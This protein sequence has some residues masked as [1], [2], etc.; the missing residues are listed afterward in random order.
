MVVVAVDHSV[1]IPVGQDVRLP[2]EDD[3]TS[4]RSLGDGR[5]VRHDRSPLWPE[6]EDRGRLG[7]HPQS[8]TI[9]EC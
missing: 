3:S 6:L 9:P 8:R 4:V 1:G 7:P 2:A 5:S